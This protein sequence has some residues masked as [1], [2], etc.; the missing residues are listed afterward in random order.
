MEIEA[1]FLPKS[2]EQRLDWIYESGAIKNT[3]SEEYL[4]GKPFEEL[5]AEEK[6]TEWRPTS[7]KESTANPANEQFTRVHE[8]PLFVIRQEELRR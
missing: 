7:F 6:N 5:E 4:L 1:G 8:D 2:R 3:S